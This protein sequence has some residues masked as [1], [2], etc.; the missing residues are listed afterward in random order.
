M[1]RRIVVGFDGSLAA[2]AAVTWAAGAAWLRGTELVAWTV[3]DRAESRHAPDSVAANTAPSSFDS[4]GGY[5][6]TLRYGHGGAAPVLVKAYAE[7]ELLVLGSRRH[8]PL[9]GLV[10]DSDIRACPA[11]APCPVVLIRP[12]PG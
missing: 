11:H 12:Q 3:L 8:G 2:L 4:A 7:A 5:P 9:E 6:V 10:L 1:T